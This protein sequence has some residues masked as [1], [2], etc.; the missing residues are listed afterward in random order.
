MSNKKI[1]EPELDFDFTTLMTP[2]D[3][4]TLAASN[5]DPSKHTALMLE[6]VQGMVSISDPI[7]DVSSIPGAHPGSRLMQ[8]SVLIPPGLF[9]ERK[10]LLTPSIGSQPPHPLEGCVTFIDQA[11]VIVPLARIEPRAKNA[12]ASQYVQAAAMMRSLQ[13]KQGD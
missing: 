8:I 5:L 3:M 13:E 11:R 2:Q 10:V 1:P 6:V 9:E 12:I 4:A 7:A